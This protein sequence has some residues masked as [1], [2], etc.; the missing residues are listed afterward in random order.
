MPPSTAGEDA[1]PLQKKT[2]CRYVIRP[3]QSCESTQWSGGILPSGKMLNGNNV[4]GLR[5]KPTSTL[6]ARSSSGWQDA[7][8]HGR[9]GRTAATESAAPAPFFCAFAKT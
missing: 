4:L 2:H 8:L 6:F 7:T 9:R 5:I 1:L 3:T